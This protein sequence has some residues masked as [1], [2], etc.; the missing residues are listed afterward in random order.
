[1]KLKDLYTDKTFAKYLNNLDTFH[2]KDMEYLTAIASYTRHEV[3]FLFNNLNQ[4]E[5]YYLFNEHKQEWQ[6]QFVEI[7]GEKPLGFDL[8][9]SLLVVNRELLQSHEYSIYNKKQ[10]LVIGN[11]DMR[12][13][14]V[15]QFENYKA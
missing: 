11:R 5:L 6:E 15:K 1:M 14:N 4:Y 12:V 7:Y 13:G 9:I 3:I 8:L 2:D 10:Q